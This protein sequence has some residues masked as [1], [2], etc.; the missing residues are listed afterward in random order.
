MFSSSYLYIRRKNKKT[1]KK[2]LLFEFRQYFQEKQFILL[3]TLMS[4]GQMFS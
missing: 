4:V 2:S 1:V 3:P